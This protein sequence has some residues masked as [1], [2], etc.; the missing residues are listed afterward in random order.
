MV[1]AYY[2]CEFMRIKEKL[3]KEN[4]CFTENWKVRRKLGARNYIIHGTVKFLFFSTAIL[5]G[6]T[7]INPNYTNDII[8]NVIIYFII[9]FLA[10]ITS[11]F[12]NEYRYSKFNR[13]WPVAGYCMV[14]KMGCYFI[15]YFKL[16]KLFWQESCS[17]IKM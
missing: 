10:P 13:I 7:L 2:V 11:W 1:Y 6:N 5:L 9:S 15:Y 8:S 12:T 14:K 16:K 4:I 3:I 17:M